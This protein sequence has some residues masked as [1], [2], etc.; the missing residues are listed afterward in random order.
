MNAD[1]ES[2]RA[3][4]PN[5]SGKE[6]L[7]VEDSLDDRRRYAGWL[8]AAG[9]RVEE[10][11]TLDAARRALSSRHRDVL[12]VDRLLPDGDALEWLH[13]EQRRGTRI[14]PCV[15]VSGHLDDKTYRLV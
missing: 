8:I 1:D 15:V 9:A 14:P 4:T 12:V 10:V 2:K 11:D 13:A 7:L 3:T 5:V 6:I